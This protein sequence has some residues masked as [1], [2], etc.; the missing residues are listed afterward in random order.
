[1]IGQAA[2]RPRQQAGDALLKDR[3]GLERDRVLVARGLQKFIDVRGGAAMAS[4]FRLDMKRAAQWLRD[5]H[6]RF[7]YVY[8]HGNLDDSKPNTHLLAHVPKHLRRA[9]KD[10]AG[11]WFEAL[12]GGVKVDP[13]N[14]AQ[15]LA[16]GQ[17]GRLQYMSKGAD[18]FTCKRYGGRR[19]KGGQGPITIKRAGVA[20]CLGVESLLLQKGGG[21]PSTSRARSCS[22]RASGRRNGGRFGR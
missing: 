21:L 15:R 17:G 22:L 3:I 11:S 12:D 4:T 19:A 18:D 20:Q 5:N 13:R 16:K 8:V 2:G 10:K 1:M 7:A 6:S 14:D 9:F